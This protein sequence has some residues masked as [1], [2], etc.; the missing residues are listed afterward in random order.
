MLGRNFI[1]EVIIMIMSGRAISMQLTKSLELSYF[2]QQAKG[3]KHM[4]IFRVTLT[5]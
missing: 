2:K 4:F 5:K 1:R 3:N